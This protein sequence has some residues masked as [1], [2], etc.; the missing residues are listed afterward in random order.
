MYSYFN[1]L[2]FSRCWFHYI[3][4]ILSSFHPSFITCTFSIQPRQPQTSKHIQPPIIIVT[5]HTLT[6]VSLTDQMSYVC[7]MRDFSY[8]HARIPLRF[9]RTIMCLNCVRFLFFFRSRVDEHIWWPVFLMSPPLDSISSTLATV[10]WAHSSII[11]PAEKYPTHRSCPSVRG[12]PSLASNKWERRASAPK[13]LQQ[14]F[15]SNR[16]WKRKKRCYRI[17]HMCRIQRNS[18]NWCE[19]FPVRTHRW[20]W[21]NRSVSVVMV[22]VLVQSIRQAITTVSMSST[23]CPCQSCNPSDTHHIIRFGIWINGSLHSS[24]LF[25]RLFLARTEWA[26]WYW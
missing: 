11:C 21:P 1:A 13:I 17:W 7:F 3:F 22:V 5:Q 15:E 25:I 24:F 9:Q 8:S 16:I 26:N 20:K 14:I 10:V 12:L 4:K 6:F 23:K 2:L 19:V 18:I